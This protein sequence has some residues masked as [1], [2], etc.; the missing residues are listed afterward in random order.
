MRANPTSRFLRGALAA[1]LACG[2]MMPTGA[3]A[4]TDEGSESTPQQSL[5]DTANGAAPSQE[6]PNDG[7]DPS[8]TPG[9]TDFDDALSDTGVQAGEPEQ[10]PSVPDVSTA[11]GKDT[12][13]KTPEHSSPAP[14]LSHEIFAAAHKAA[15]Q[16]VETTFAARASAVNPFTVTG[17]KEGAVKGQGDYFYDAGEGTLHIQTSTPLTI[18]TTAQVS[19]NIEIDAGVKADLTLDGV[20]IATPSDGTTSPINMVT[21]VTD[22]ADKKRATHANDILRPTM[23]HLTLADKSDNRLACLNRASGGAGSPGIRCGWGSVLVI[24]D[25]IRNLD[26]DNNIVMPENGMVAKAVTLANGTHLEAGAPLALM[27]SKNPGS[28]T[29]DAG[30]NSAAIG[31]GPEENAGKLIFQ[32]GNIYANGCNQGI[33]DNYSPDTGAAIGGG[34]GGSGTVMIFNGGNIIATASYHGA[35][36]GSGWGWWKRGGDT[37]AKPDAIAIP[38]YSSVPKVGEY[39]GYTFW[40]STAGKF[41]TVAGDIYI[42]GGY[43]E[44]KGAEHGNGFGSACL[45]TTSSN[46]NHVIRVTGG[47]LLPSSTNV[48][49]DMGGNN[50]YVVITGGSVSLTKKS[51]GKPDESKFQGIG[52]TA[53]NTAGITTWNDVLNKGGSLPDDDKV[54]MITINLGSEIN[55]RNTEAGITNDDKL[56]DRINSWRLTVGGKEYA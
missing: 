22:T 54:F 9:A 13:A 55:K 17:G 42:N 40:N 5:A 53:F 43:I 30:G 4:A 25:E 20:D 11:S 23:L 49:K 37:A 27:D 31:S 48:N 29:V 6:V 24:D 50:G 14:S 3:L 10:N 45:Y 38:T 2:L 33:G 7:D 47:T 35:A 34:N 16:A 15:T 32:G 1:V 28:L 46:R 41:D 56:D 8:G 21:N 19:E 18:S 44:A 26:S 51:D 52:D 39:D 36:I 12:D